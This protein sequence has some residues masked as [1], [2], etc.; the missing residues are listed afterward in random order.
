VTLSRS[1]LLLAVVLAASVALSQ[2]RAAP[3]DAETC[4]K[5]MIEQ[6]ALESAGVEQNMAKG[7]AWAMA[8]L[9]PE[10]IEQVRRFIE[11]EELILFRCRS[12]VRVTLPPDPEDKEPDQDKDS[13]KDKKDQ[14]ADGQDKGGEAK[15]ETVVVKTPPSAKGKEPTTQTEVRA[16]SEPKADPKKQKAQPPKKPP[17]DHSAKAG[18]PKAQPKAAPKKQEPGTK[19]QTKAPTQPPPKAPPKTGAAASQKPPP[20]AKVEEQPSAED[21]TATEASK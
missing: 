5:L 12:K 7:P 10:K 11:L 13:S 6:G 14:A 15:N 8:N 16:T 18:D 4:N 2:A 21:G 20:K 19:P 1:L 17:S 3:L 9:T